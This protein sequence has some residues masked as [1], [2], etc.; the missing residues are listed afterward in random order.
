M[1]IKNLAPVVLRLGLAMVFI[2]FGSNQ[3]MSQ[4]MWMWLIPKSLISMTGISAQNIVIGNGIF[5]IIMAALLA[6][7]I[8]I[9]LVAILLALHLLGIIG[10]LG[11][12]A[13]GIRDIGLFF[14]MVSVA[15]HG[16]DIYSYDKDSLNS[17]NI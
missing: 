2:W 1:K 13:I 9:R 10:V 3:L 4:T 7:G 11:I 8:W 15:M 16:A 17:L 12:N 6:F 5:E 14:A